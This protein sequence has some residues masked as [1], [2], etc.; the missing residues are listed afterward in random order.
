MGKKIHGIPIRKKFNGKYYSL[1]DIYHNDI[2]PKRLRERFKE[3]F[4]YVRIVKLKRSVLGSKGW[5]LAV[6]FNGH[7]K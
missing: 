7:L 4:K 2:D 3:K 5:I 1:W 6:Y